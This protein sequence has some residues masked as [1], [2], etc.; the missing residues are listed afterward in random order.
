[1]TEIVKIVGGI[2]DFLIFCYQMDL[3]KKPIRKIID[4][5]GNVIRYE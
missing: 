3:K 5:H 4:K 2:I 1:L